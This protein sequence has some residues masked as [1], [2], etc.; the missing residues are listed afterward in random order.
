MTVPW[1]LLDDRPPV[2]PNVGPFAHGAFLSLLWKHLELPDSAAKVVGNGEGAVAFQFVDGE[3]SLLGPEHLIDY[4]SPLGDAGGLI[5]RVISSLPTG[6]SIRLDSMPAEAVEVFLMALAAAGIEAEAHEH[7][8]AAVLRLPATYDE[9]LHGLGKK[10]RH[11]TRRKRRRLT[12]ALGEPRL[13]TFDHPGPALIRFFR[14]HRMAEGGKG[15]FMTPKMMRF[16]TDLLAQP[17]WQLDTL[18]GDGNRIA[19]AVIGFMNDEGYFLYNSAYDV[20]LRHLSPGVVLLN[21][22][23]E[24]SIEAGHQVF[25]FLKGDETY[26]Y[27]M[28]AE[29]RPLFGLRATA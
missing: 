24:R 18:Y 15:E 16:F 19:A 8:S 21:S 5:S 22:L 10:E 25:D 4:R 2:A 7:D 29:P 11:E 26:K 27:R 6:T 28:G 14:L 12:E 23:I 3:L 13:V 1:N 20:E 9:Y 17:G